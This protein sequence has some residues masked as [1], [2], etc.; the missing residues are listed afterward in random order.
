MNNAV[1]VCPER[2]IECGRNSQAW[3]ETCPER[4]NALVIG[5]FSLKV[6]PRV[7]EG[8][9]RVTIPKGREAGLPG[10]FTFNFPT[11]SSVDRVSHHDSLTMHKRAEALEKVREI[12][13]GSDLDGVLARIRKLVNDCP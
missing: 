4:Q 10:A 1:Q 3:C 6:D 7:P 12:L 11:G 13:S 9:V 2:D 8:T 5:G